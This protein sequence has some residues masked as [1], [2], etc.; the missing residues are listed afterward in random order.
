MLQELLVHTYL[1]LEEAEE[2]AAEARTFAEHVLA[3]LE[4]RAAAAS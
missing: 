1:K 4:R 2:T 3:E